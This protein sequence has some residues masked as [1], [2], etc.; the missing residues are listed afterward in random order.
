[1]EDKNYIIRC[2]VIL[3]TDIGD[4]IDDTWAL[5]MLLKSPELDVKLVAADT[6]DTTYRAKIIARIL[7]VAGRTDIPV[8]VGIPDVGR[9]TRKTQATWVEDYNLEDYSGDVRLDGVQ[10]IIDTIMESPDPVTLICI[11]PVP[12]I[13]EALRREPDIAR[14]VRFVGMH[15]SFHWHHTT[16]RKLSMEPGR[17]AEWNVK[18]DISSAQE[19]FSAPWIDAVITPLDTCAR[20]VL[21]GERYRRLLKSDDPLIRAVI[22]NYRIWAQM[23]G[24]DSDPATHTSVLFDCVAVYLAYSTRFL[25]MER[26]GLRVDEGGHTIEDIGAPVFNVAIE[27]LNYE[28][29]AD[30]LVERLLSPVVNE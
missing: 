8:A 4:D 12:N 25:K 7:E 13:A 28:A 19:V 10:A 5:A 30:E 15:G 9:P 17:Q 14:R 18:C 1:M 27:W 22:D 26:M 24:D 20:V 6:A 3:D 16:N 29:F 2:P 11:G 23:H 21:D